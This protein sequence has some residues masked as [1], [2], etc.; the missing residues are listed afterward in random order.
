MFASVFVAFSVPSAASTAS[1]YFII[2]DANPK[3]NRADRQN[4]I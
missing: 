1:P 2:N 3:I 4:G